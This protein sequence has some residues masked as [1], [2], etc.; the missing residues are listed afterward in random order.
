MRARRQRPRIGIPHQ[1]CLDFLS[2]LL[3]AV[4]SHNKGRL[5]VDN[6]TVTH[7]SFLHSTAHHDE[8]VASFSG[9]SHCEWAVKKWGRAPRNRQYQLPQKV[10]AT[11]N[12]AEGNK[13]QQQKNINLGSI[14]WP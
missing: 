8:F 5:K 1:E 3:F 13:L 6:T 14:T 9:S 7:W 12:K 2:C 4:A 10:M 11:K